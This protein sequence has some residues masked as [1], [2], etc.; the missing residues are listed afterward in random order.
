LKIQNP[1]LKTLISVGGTSEGSLKYSEM[2][3]TSARRDAF[4]RSVVAFLQLHGFDGLDLD[5]EYPGGKPGVIPGLPDDKANFASLLRELRGAFDEHGFLLSV[6]ASPEPLVVN[7][8]YDVPAMAEAVDFIGL[9]TY[10]YHFWYYSLGSIAFNLTGHHAPLFES[11]EEVDPIHPGHN[12]NVDW[13]VNNWLQLGARPEQLLVGL[14]TYGAGFK[15]TNPAQ[16]GLYALASGPSAAGPYLQ[17]EGVLAYN[18][19]CERMYVDGEIDM[20]TVVRD[21]NVVSPYTYD[22]EEWFGYEDSLSVQ[23]KARFA[24]ATGLGGVAVLS[25]DMDDY[26]D[27][28]NEG[29]F[30]LTATA[31]RILNG[32]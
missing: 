30:S 9:T 26:Y 10:N 15:L 3:S 11:P 7:Q 2:V 25:L 5:W 20:W 22:G 29:R 32:R 23:A 8:A 19:Y 12:K 21:P 31:A 14:A 4:I 27:F 16:N 17:T 13:G 28:C 6:T 18:E 24:L 1:S